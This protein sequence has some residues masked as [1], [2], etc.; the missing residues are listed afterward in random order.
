[1]V[2]S[3]SQIIIIIIN[4]LSL[5]SESFKFF[6]GERHTSHI[7]REWHRTTNYDVVIQ[8]YGNFVLSCRYEV[9]Q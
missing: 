9:T 1:M 7:E 5:L 4:C 3:T 2:Y 6:S 8:Q